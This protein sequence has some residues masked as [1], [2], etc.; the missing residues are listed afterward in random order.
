[1][2]HN[3]EENID[4]LIE[5][6]FAVLEGIFSQ[7]ERFAELGQGEGKTLFLLSLTPE[8]LSSGALSIK[9]ELST[10]RIANILH[11]LEAK[12]LITR[13]TNPENK[14]M[15]IIKL[16]ETG[17]QHVS[18]TMVEAKGKAADVL[19]RLGREDAETLIR[20]FKKLS[21]N[22]ETDPTSRTPEGI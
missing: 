2:A 5:E 22:K 19:C 15:T 9:M 1:M 13:T 4:D 8:G 14:R 21:D 11:Q 10:G 17:F 16:T 7:S 20:I 18:K 12:G 6:W 3:P